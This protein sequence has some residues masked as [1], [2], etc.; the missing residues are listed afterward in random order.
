M[1]RRVL[2]QWR[3]TQRYQSLPSADED[4]LTGAVIAQGQ[5]AGPIRVQEYRGAARHRW[6]AG[7]SRADGVGLAAGGAA[8]AW[9]W[10]G[11]AGMAALPGSETGASVPSVD[12]VSSVDSEFSE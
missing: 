7:E 5:P 4:E 9:D 1:T 11:V 3:G 6:L 2:G 12:S 10:F 8:E